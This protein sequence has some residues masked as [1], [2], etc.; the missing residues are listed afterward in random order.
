MLNRI[1]AIAVFSV[2]A[3]PAVV[4]ADGGG[5]GG[6]PSGG[7]HAMAATETQTVK[8]VKTVCAC[9]TESLAGTKSVCFAMS[10][11]TAAPAQEAPQ[12]SNIDL[13]PEDYR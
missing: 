8:E 6:A 11:T 1:L 10:P 13:H 2:L 5:G 12:L 4:S 3:I 9:M 7:R